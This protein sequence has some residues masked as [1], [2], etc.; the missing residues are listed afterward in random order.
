MHSVSSNAM[1]TINAFN[2]QTYE[3]IANLFQTIVDD[4]LDPIVTNVLITQ[5]KD[6]LESERQWKYLLGLDQTQTANPGDTYQ[7]AK[8]L[9]SDF[10]FPLESGI[11][12]GTD[13][14]P[15]VQFPFED[16]LFYQSISHGYFID[17]YNNNY[18]ILGQPNPGGV[19]NFFY[20][21]FTLPLAPL[22][23]NG[24]VP[25]GT[26]NQPKFPARFRALIAYYAAIRYFAINQDQK[27]STWDDRWT[28]F[29][30][31]IHDNMVRW[32][33]RI[34]KQAYANR[35]GAARIDFSSYPNIIT[36]ML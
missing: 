27:S 13:T 11:Y 4:T 18:F 22:G 20:Q 15:Y 12:I 9:P 17:L 28:T 23:S 5:G 29:F 16:Q 14:I 6:D 26:I 7:T 32:D 34:A 30:A 19:I 25:V 31:A 10:A 1:A 2:I 33:F 36:G 35:A 3:D 24:A 21:K 8:T